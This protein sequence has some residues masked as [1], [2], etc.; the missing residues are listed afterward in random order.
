MK[1]ISWQLFVLA[2]LF[3]ACV[4]TYD[5]SIEGSRKYLIV[6]GTITNVFDEDQT[7]RIF[8]T[9]DQSDFI[10][11]DFT[12]TIFSKNNEAVPVENASVEVIENGSIIYSLNEIFPGFYEL[13][14]GFLAQIG[15]EYQLKFSTTE[16]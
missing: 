15:N 8:E 12:K 3:L 2:F 7:I 10:S 9:D 4:D 13:P 16:G 11:T 5:V 14:N 1:L 6:E